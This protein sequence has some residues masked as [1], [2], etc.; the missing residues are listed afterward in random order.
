MLAQGRRTVQPR[1]AVRHP[2]TAK[3]APAPHPEGTPERT[4]SGALRV[5]LGAR[6][7]GLGAVFARLSCCLYYRMS[8]GCY[9]GNCVLRRRVR[10]NA[11]VTERRAG[12]EEAARAAT[13]RAIHEAVTDTWEP[14]TL[15]GPLLVATVLPW[16]A[17]VIHTHDAPTPHSAPFWTGFGLVSTATRRAE[18]ARRAA[19]LQFKVTACHFD[20]STTEQHSAASPPCGESRQPAGNGLA[21]RHALQ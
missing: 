9:C 14:I 4:R 6:A 21:N 20:S 7:P 2:A 15:L 18:P 17:R 12:G 10:P 16:L 1:R 5:L 11:A 13:R 19:G 8:G 3:E